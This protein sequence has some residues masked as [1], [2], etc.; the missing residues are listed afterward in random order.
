MTLLIE[1]EQNFYTLREIKGKVVIFIGF[2][3]LHHL[4]MDNNILKTS[5]DDFYELVKSRKKIS[6]EEAAKILRMPIDV[7]QA[8]ADF[9]VEERIFGIEYK[10][11]TP[12]VYL[13]EKGNHKLHAQPII[14]PP[15]LQSNSKLVTK[16]EFYNKASSWNMPQD[17]VDN[18]WK[19][20]L[21]ENMDSLKEAFFEKARS[22]NLPEEKVNGLW[23][24][25]KSSLQ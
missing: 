10:F 13:N 11:T 14:P 23:E 15:K 9:L 18:L 12:Y 5:A 1:N 16:E 4:K 17:K 20:Y 7:V 22:K 24:K 19:K 6:I 25:Y 3:S 8:V 2:N 21:S